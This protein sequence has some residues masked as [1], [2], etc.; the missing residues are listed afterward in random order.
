MTSKKQT[1]L[2][3]GLEA[4][5]G[6]AVV[7]TAATNGMVVDAEGFDHDSMRQSISIDQL[8]GTL[9]PPEVVPGSATQSIKFQFGLVGNGTAGAGPK[10]SAELEAGGM[11]KT[12]LTAPVRTEYTI[13]QSG[14]KSA[15]KVLYWG[16]QKATGRWMYNKTIIRVETNKAGVIVCEALG[17]YDGVIVAAIPG[18]PGTVIRPRVGGPKR[19]SKFFVGAAYAAGALTGGAEF[20]FSMCEVDIGQQ[21]DV[22]DWCGDQD[23]S[24]TKIEPKFKTTIN[25]SPAEYVTMK[26][27]R[28]AIGQGFSG[29]YKHGLSVTGADVPGETVIVFCPNIVPTKVLKK[30]EVNNVIVA[31]IE[32][33][34]RPTTP[35]GTDAVRVIYL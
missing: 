26:D 23:V 3:S 19:T 28:E 14:Y 31:E 34:P 20:P 9:S 13:A 32:G 4:T 2:L 7:L 6:T 5:S 17:L 29:G 15:T 35:G 24:I 22:G 30:A 10:Y 16:D 1:L 33:V 12:A 18:A 25:L 27:T 21:V 11:A 8:D